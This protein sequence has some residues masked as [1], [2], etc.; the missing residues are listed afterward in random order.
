MDFYKVFVS[1]GDE[2][3]N[4]S[5]TREALHDWLNFLVIMAER[6]AKCRTPNAQ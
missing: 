5:K 6:G 4:S 1:F 3:I 2:L